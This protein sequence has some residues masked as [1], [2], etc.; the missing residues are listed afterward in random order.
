MPC[1]MSRTRLRLCRI[2]YGLVPMNRWRLITLAGVVLIIAVGY[3]RWSLSDH[4]H[5]QAQRRPVA[6]PA[7]SQTARAGAQAFALHCGG[8]HGADAGGAA[9]GPALVDPIYRSAHHADAS[10]L[11]AVRR[12]VPAHHWRF[13]NMPPV[14]AVPADD[15]ASIIRY[16][17]EVQKANG[18]E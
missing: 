16:V 14:P 10:F 9:G 2:G 1:H 8:C 5:P 17:R 3:L 18:I 7:L 4:G 6:V 12:G 11:L 15:L 13:G